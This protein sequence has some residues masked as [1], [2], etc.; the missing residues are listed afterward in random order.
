MVFEAHQRYCGK[1]NTIIL[2]NFRRLIT[3]R[4]VEVH[5]RVPLAPGIT[6]TEENLSAIA[7]LLRKY[8]VKRVWPV[9]YNPLG[10]VKFQTLGRPAP[11]IQPTFMKQE[12]EQKALEILRV[13][14]P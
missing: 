13:K 11:K 10:L 8:G 12:Q 14:H 4:E 3:E 2:E 1:P 6:D 7:R 9:P 5:P